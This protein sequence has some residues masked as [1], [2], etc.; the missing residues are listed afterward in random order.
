MVDYA[1]LHTNQ[2]RNFE[3]VVIGAGVGTTDPENSIFD[4]TVGESYFRSGERDSPKG[5]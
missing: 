2:D 5:K 4:I 1:I 3:A